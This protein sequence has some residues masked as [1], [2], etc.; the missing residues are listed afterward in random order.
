[1]SDLDITSLEGVP[2]TH[3]RADVGHG[4][5][6]HYVEAG[7]GP[8]VLLLHGFPEFWYSFRQQIPALARAGFR[9]VA[10]DLRGYNRSDRPREVSAYT[11]EQLADDVAGLIRACGEESALVVGH[12]WG[13]G[14]A[15]AF[16]MA[17]PAMLRRLAIL[18][19][20]HP[21]RLLRGLASPVQLARSWYMFFFQIPRLPEALL[22]FD[23]VDRLLDSI[24]REARPGAFT[25][26]DLALYREALLQPGAL[27]AM[28]NYY[29][30]AARHRPKLRP[31]E[32]PV[33]VLWGDLDRHLG[34]ALAR[35]DARLVPDVRVVHIAGASHWVQHDAPD[36]V[37]ERLIGFL[38]EA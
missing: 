11:S 16:A 9:V 14:V 19:C 8:L 30:A 22:A 25:D 32:A 26:Q 17:H 28:I 18:N 6:L 10:P 23:R 1:M 7:E 29:R 34:H 15:W 5:T 3:Q 27:R 2:V 4:V 35:P 12:D 36:E 13:G 21:A 31:V 37:N 24:R 33:L 38:R 20:P